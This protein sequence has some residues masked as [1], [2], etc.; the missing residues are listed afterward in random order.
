MDDYSHNITDDKTRLHWFDKKLGT[1]KLPAQRQCRHLANKWLEKRWPPPSD[2][3]A[4]ETS[5]LN[6]FYGKKCISRRDKCT[7]AHRC[8]YLLYSYLV[9]T[10]SRASD[11]VASNYSSSNAAR[12]K[13]KP[14]AFV[15]TTACKSLFNHNGGKRRHTTLTC[16]RID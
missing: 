7:R 9:T 11:G 14:N 3:L 10:I 6:E 1:I 12:G 8:F 2:M 15:R 4:L 5:T 13:K 16:D